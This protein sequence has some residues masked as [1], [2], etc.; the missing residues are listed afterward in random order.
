MNILVLIASILLGLAMVGAG[1]AK[2]RHQEP[3]TSTLDR[4][5]VSRSLQRTIGFLE[6]LGG[7]GVALGGVAIT[8]GSPLGWLGVAAA[9]GLVLMM[10]GA[11][12][13]HAKERDTLKNS[14]GALIL[15]VFS[16]AVAALQILTV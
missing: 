5:K 12:S 8:I 13:W 1:T 9:I 7:I 15:F 10:A 4:L 2:V 16:G 14:S 3:V 11:L 6:V